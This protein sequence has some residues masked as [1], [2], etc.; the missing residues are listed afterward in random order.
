MTKKIVALLLAA[1]LCVGML[2]A[3]GSQQ[4]K[5][6]EDVAPAEDTAPAEETTPAEEPESGQP[7]EPEEEAH[8]MFL[9][10][11]LPIRTLRLTGSDRLR[12]L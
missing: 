8:T 6:A 3:C 5:P 9:W 12:R 1:L 2:A 10:I 4:T 7:V 11:K